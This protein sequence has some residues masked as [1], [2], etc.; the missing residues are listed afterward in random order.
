MRLGV[1]TLTCLTQSAN[2]VVTVGLI[3]GFKQNAKTSAGIKCFCINDAHVCSSFRNCEL[4][5]TF[6]LSR[7]SMCGF[8][9]RR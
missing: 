9:L 2:T 1:S 6:F 7:G 5:I 4:L 3:L 8:A